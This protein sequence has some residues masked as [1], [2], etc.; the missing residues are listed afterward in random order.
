MRYGGTISKNINNTV[1]SLLAAGLISL[2]PVMHAAAHQ[3]PPGCNSSRLNVS[4]VKD[5]TEVYQGQTLT[6][7]VTVSNLDSGTDIACDITDATIDVTLP[8]RDGTPTGQVVNL[9]T[10]QDYPAGT[11]VT[12]I[13][14]IPYIVDVNESV[15]DIVAEVSGTGTLHD[16]PVDH[17]ALIVKTLGTSVVAAPDIP[18]D[19]PEDGGGSGS[20]TPGLPNT[21]TKVEL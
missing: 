9:V 15:I 4:I 8:N 7:T 19:A 21:G 14:T 6:Y 11:A 2:F 3:N 1:F 18:S 17:A 20:D 16:A 10:N 12:L 5:R 13:G